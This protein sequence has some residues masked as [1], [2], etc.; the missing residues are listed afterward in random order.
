MK[1]F[2]KD[3]LFNLNRNS[4][5][6]II[7]FLLLIS[8]TAIQLNRTNSTSTNS[9]EI[10]EIRALNSTAERSKIYLQ[11]IERVGPIQAQ[12]EL[13][14]SGLPFDGQTHLLNH[15]M[16]DYL[17]SKYGLNGLS[18]CKDYFLSSCYHGFVIR[19]IGN[20]GEA[21]LDRVM[22]SCW[23]KGNNVAAQCSHSIGHGL[24]AWNGYANLTRALES[25]DKVGDLSKDFPLFN[26]YDG[27]FMEN[28]WAIHEGK[29]SPDRWVK[30]SDPFYPCNDPRIDPK[31]LGGCW[32][33]QPSLMYQLFGGNIKKV[34]EECLKVGE[35]SLKRT[36]FD[37]LA[38]QIHPE[39]FG[40]VDKVFSL[41]SLVPKDWVEECVLTIVG[42]FYSVGDHE[43]PFKICQR[44]DGAEKMRCE[45]R[46]SNLIRFNF[47]PEGKE[48]LCERITT[49][50]PR[51]TCL[52]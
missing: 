14:N 11:L 18:F 46:L 8:G 47:S 12:E 9:S 25:C 50:Q 29:P 24:L 20:E 37:G 36:C 27:V 33:N 22:S 35:P 21:A 38:R 39:T 7:L 17:Y 26:C 23:D 42:A 30:N 16:G 45:D 32:S 4:T 19:V 52:K 51:E 28:I 41:C 1:I 49:P 15:T 44:L 2:K 13:K 48:V 6:K 3:F 5:L 43:V 34:G 40:S 31:Y 10:K